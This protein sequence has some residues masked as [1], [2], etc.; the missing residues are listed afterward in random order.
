MKND[1]Y[2]IEKWGKIFFKILKN[3][4][5][6]LLNPLKKS[7]PPVDLT[8]II[9]SLNK[10]LS[11]P[12]II[13]VADYLEYMINDINDSF[14]KSIRSI[15]YKNKFKSIYPIKVNQQSQVVKNVIK[16]GKKFN[17]GLEVGS[18]AE[19]LIAL[20]QN[21]TKDALIV[22]NGTK[23]KEFINLSLLA[24]KIEIKTIIVIESLRELDLIIKISNLL[25]IKPLLGIRI[26][27]TNVVSGKWSQS[28][29]DRSAFGLPVNKITEALNKLK[30]NNLLDCLILQHSHL[31][32]QV[33]DIIEIRKYT[34]EA[35]RFF[36]EIFNY[37]A[38]L[39]YLDLGGGL[40]VDYT[41]ENKSKFHSIN[42]TMEEYCFNIVETLK[43]ELD[44]VK[45]NHPIIITESGR[46][47]VA[48]SSILIFNILDTTIFNVKSC[49][50]LNKADHIY[51]SYMI[52]ILKYI[53]FDRIQECFNDLNYYR[54]ELRIL[55]RNGQINLSEISKVE[56]TYLYVLNQIKKFVKKNQLSSNPINSKLKNLADIYHGN[57]SLFQSLPD[58]WAIDQLH[59]I[60]PI[61][62]LN[63]KPNRN[64]IINDITC[65]SD[66]VI[67]KFVLKNGISDTLPLHDIKNNDEYYLGVFFIGAY[68]ETLGDLHNLFGD[69]NISTVKLEDNGKFKVIHEQT[70]DKISQV[71][72]YVEYSSNEVLNTFTGITEKFHKK[73]VINS[74][75]KNQLL[76]NFKASIDG[77]TYFE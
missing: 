47:T 51:L 23:D 65:D 29:G 72:N 14:N 49:P 24:N 32:S 62:K 30:L 33:P 1:I 77:Y 22:C 56:K 41:G 75:E 12:Y 16:F 6:G 5:L 48:P 53:T 3:G 40:G 60:A 52:Q 34:Q 2:G 17:S 28:S 70:G 58:M 18:K 57:F 55:F 59:P 68:Q 61:Q 71:L 4:N 67:S 45:I 25:K 11:P 74:K 9:K 10:N 21:L 7:N 76:K 66:G 54:D 20:S 26:K 27:L 46:A 38:P 63:R 73:N 42:Y 35:C 50:K 44:K 69:T 31:G 19:L 36:I 39:K 13:R 64:V 15:G 43:L 37:G 8:S